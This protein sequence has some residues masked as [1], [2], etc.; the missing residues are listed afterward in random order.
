MIFIIARTLTC[1]KFKHVLE[2][3]KER[4]VLSKSSFW[5][6]NG[7]LW[8]RIVLIGITLD[9]ECSLMGYMT[10]DWYNITF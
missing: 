8:N 5:L 9:A 2:I 1:P 3:M 6:S 7:C 10:V 4:N